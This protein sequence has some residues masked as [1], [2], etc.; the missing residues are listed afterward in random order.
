MVKDCQCQSINQRGWNCSKSS[1]HCAL[2]LAREAWPFPGL[3]ACEC[4]LCITCSFYS[5]SVK[6]IE[7]SGSL[8]LTDP[9][10]VRMGQLIFSTVIQA[11]GVKWES[12]VLPSYQS[13][14]SRAG[15]VSITDQEYTSHIN[16]FLPSELQATSFS[17]FAGRIMTIPSFHA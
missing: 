15:F 17:S 13:F 10:N 2:M 16:I 5:C 4:E 7:H 1:V 12:P 9:C 8:I 14:D 11:V 3:S 6:E